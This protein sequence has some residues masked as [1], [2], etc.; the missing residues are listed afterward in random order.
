ML[1]TNTYI[2]NDVIKMTKIRG[3]HRYY[4]KQGNNNKR[5]LSTNCLLQVQDE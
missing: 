4:G 3:S 2:E 5:T 1:R